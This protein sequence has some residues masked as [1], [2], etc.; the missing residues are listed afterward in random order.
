MGSQRVGHDWATEWKQ[1]SE[2]Q[3]KNIKIVNEYGQQ[4]I[5]ESQPVDKQVWKAEIKSDRLFSLT[6]ISQV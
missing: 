2:K 4:Y 6:D 3:K 5:E 1:Q